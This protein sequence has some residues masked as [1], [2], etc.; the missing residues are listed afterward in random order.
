MLFVQFSGCTLPYQVT[1]YTEYYFHDLKVENNRLLT[2][3]SKEKYSPEVSVSAAM[4]NEMST[5][6]AYSLLSYA[7]LS[8][9]IGD[10]ESNSTTLNLLDKKN[11]VTRKALKTINPYVREKIIDWNKVFFSYDVLMD[12]PCTTMLILENDYYSKHI[13]CRR[14]IR[15]IEM[16][17]DR[18]TFFYIKDN[19]VFEYNVAKE[20]ISEFTSEYFGKNF[21]QQFDNTSYVANNGKW[22]FDRVGEDLKTLSYQYELVDK[23]N[24]VQLRRFLS[25]Y[26]NFQDFNNSLENSK[27]LGFS[28]NIGLEILDLEGKSLYF[29]QNETIKLI[30]RAVLHEDKV[31]AAGI[32]TRETP[33][34]KKEYIE[35]I[36]WDYKNDSVIKKYYPCDSPELE[37]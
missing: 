6:K 12:R 28:P 25:K 31:Y 30:S 36:Q 4:M 22:F 2:L 3:I 5:R 32:T 19:Q 27:I 24:N 20:V 14:D 21:I 33:L 26:R 34:G 13:T 1:S 10:F 18:S 23:K 35:I 37:M 7:L 11:I 29:L 16:S 17:F 8:F 9:D 15:N